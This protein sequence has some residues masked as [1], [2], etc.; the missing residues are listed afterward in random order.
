[1]HVLKRGNTGLQ[2]TWYLFFI[3]FS[4][5]L[6]TVLKHG[7]VLS[8]R[9]YLFYICNL[10][11]HEVGTITILFLQ[12]KHKYR[13]IV[14]IFA[15]IKYCILLL[16]EPLR[17]K[18]TLNV[19]ALFCKY[20]WTICSSLALFCCSSFFSNI[21]LNLLKTGQYIWFSRSGP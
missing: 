19:I 14:V 20:Y 1:M 12:L 8:K 13:K 2:S 17:P 4:C 11:T 18:L 21:S 5:V 6:R 7:W 15:C 16:H 9:S 10:F 3:M